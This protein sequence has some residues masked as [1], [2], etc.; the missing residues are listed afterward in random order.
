MAFVSKDLKSWLDINT[1][2]QLI[3]L[4]KYILLQAVL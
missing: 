1:G 2:S 4:K 3:N